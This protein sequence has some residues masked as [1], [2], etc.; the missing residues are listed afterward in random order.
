MASSVLCRNACV[1]P[2][3]RARNLDV[4]KTPR[5]M[6]TF[7]VRC[8]CTGPMPP[9]SQ[10]SPDT[11]TP[12]MGVLGREPS[13]TM[14]DPGPRHLVSVVREEQGSVNQRRLMGRLSVLLVAGTLLTVST[15]VP[16]VRGQDATPRAV[17]A[18]APDWS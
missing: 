7:L 1:I 4:R 17:T 16:T 10:R 8:I 14:H 15:G 11:L 2:S 12:C 3:P 5:H 6:T 13:A 9:R 18:P